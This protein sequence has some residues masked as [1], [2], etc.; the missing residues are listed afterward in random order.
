MQQLTKFEH[1]LLSTNQNITLRIKRGE[2]GGGGRSKIFRYFR[3]FTKDKITYFLR[4]VNQMHFLVIHV[5]Y[6][7]TPW[8]IPMQMIIAV[9]AMKKI[10]IDSVFAVSRN[11]KK[12]K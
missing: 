5:A 10:S 4:L 2:M 8:R 6:Q 9:I 12:N 3:L 1:I 11:I 7:N